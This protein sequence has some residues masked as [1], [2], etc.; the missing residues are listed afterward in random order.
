MDALEGALSELAA[1]GVEGIPLVRALIRRLLQLGQ[2]RAE[3][4]G[5]RTTSDVLASAGRSLFWKDRD[6]IQRQLSRWRPD[7]IQRAIARLTEVE[8]AI[9]SSGSAGPILL[10]EEL[11]AIGRAVQRMR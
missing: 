7:A 6:A 9:K 8:R 4:Q 3:I 1:A 11:F 5:T 10:D 2:F